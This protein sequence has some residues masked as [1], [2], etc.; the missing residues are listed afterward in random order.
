M[1]VIYL[2]DTCKRKT[3]VE[4]DPRRPDPIRCNIT[5]KCRGRLS[6]DEIRTAK[7][8]LYPAPVVGLEDFT[9]R[10]TPAP[11]QP[12]Q[13]VENPISL[14]TS[15]NGLLTLALLRRSVTN[16]VASFYVKDIS[17]GDF[18]IEEQ[19]DTVAR[20]QTSTVRLTLFELIPELLDL[21]RYTYKIS[22][23]VQIVRGADDTQE[24]HNLRF[25]TE[26]SIRV[27]VNGILLPETAYD[28]S[29]VNQITFT[30]AVVDTNNIVEVIV[31]SDIDTIIDQ[32]DQVTIDFKPLRPEVEA[33]AT[34]RQECCWGD[35]GSTSVNGVTRFLL[36]SSEI[37]KLKADKS[38]GVASIE[39]ISSLTG[40]T[41]EILETEVCLM[42][43]KR[44]FSFSDKELQ[45]F[46]SGVDMI[47]E[48]IILTYTRG[49]ITGE[50]EL[51]V[52]ETSVTQVFNQI[53]PT[54]SSKITIESTVAA[55]STSPKHGVE[56]INRK[57]IFGPT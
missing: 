5:R 6:R 53:V 52:D 44:P 41:K 55:V 13:A 20:P 7:S 21:R 43:G 46:V 22:G 18:T 28:R 39:G 8:L 48:D 37:T 11:I 33:E 29:V 38:Y 51:S 16:N 35:Y 47:T 23:I 2:C 24:G 1:Y 27:F 34:L 15:S 26:D 14:L 9:P 49:K 12:A 25:T 17:G 42:I 50:F 3:E 56:E 54:A 57:F 40:E 30:P 31:Y 32:A 4:L 10:G 36:F 19:L 45:A